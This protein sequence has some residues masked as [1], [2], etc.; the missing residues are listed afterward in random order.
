MVNL[1][2]THFEDSVNSE[3]SSQLD[4]SENLESLTKERAIIALS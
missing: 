1:I 2:L 3:Y 4:I